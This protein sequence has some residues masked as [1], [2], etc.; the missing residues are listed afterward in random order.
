MSD[1]IH[2]IF[3]NKKVNIPKL[4][5]CGFKTES[6]KYIYIKSL[7]QKE[8]I[9]TVTV[10]NK[11]EISANIIDSNFNEPYTLHLVDSAAGSFVGDVKRQYE[12]I[13]TQIAM[14]C[15]DYDV[16]KS[17][18]AKELIEYVKNTYK[19]DLEFLW[20][21]FPNN[22]IWRRKDT[23]KWYGA[24]LTVEKSKL[25]VKSE[26][27]VEIID[28]RAEPQ[29]IEVLINNQL[30]FPGYHM[31]KKHWYTIILDNSISTSEICRR[32]DDSYLLAHK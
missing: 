19:D 2:S 8:L 20:K 11:D 22:A 1:I 10:N 28:L 27:T 17:T 16:F 29:E 24:L 7:S 23:G 15:F 4:L 3:K 14:Q 12:E 9:L 5:N 6:S 31:N 30:Y 18:Q 13:L 21:K 26:E 32:I 25:G